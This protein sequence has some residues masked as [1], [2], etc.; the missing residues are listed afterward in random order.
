MI[1]YEDAMKFGQSRKTAGSIQSQSMRKLRSDD[2]LSIQQ[3]L[4][5]QTNATVTERSQGSPRSEQRHTKNQ[6]KKCTSNS[7]DQR[8]SDNSQLSKQAIGKRSS[9]FFL[10]RMQQDKDKQEK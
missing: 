10:A 6:H 8:I 9:F 3:S 4:S 2:Y 5:F 7:L 1:E